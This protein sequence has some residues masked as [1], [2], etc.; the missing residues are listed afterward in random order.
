MRVVCFYPVE[1]KHGVRLQPEE[2]EE[3]A[4]IAQVAG[5]HVG[6]CLFEPCLLRRI[7]PRKVRLA[8]RKTYRARTKG[9]AERDLNLAV[10]DNGEVFR[11]GSSKLD[12]SL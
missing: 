9:L 6:A 8:R 1:L 12:E 7:E 4:R 3:R 2:T 11:I 5:N 10:A